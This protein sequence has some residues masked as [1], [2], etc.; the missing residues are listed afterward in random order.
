MWVF[1]FTLGG[2][3]LSY[4]ESSPLVA[5]GQQLS[6]GI[7]PPH[8]PKIPPVTMTKAHRSLDSIT[9]HVTFALRLYVNYGKSL[10]L[11]V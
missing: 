6:L 9:Q 2:L 5:M 3:A 7:L 10:S 1:V 8:L 11:C 4:E